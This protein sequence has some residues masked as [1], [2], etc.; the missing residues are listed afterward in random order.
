MTS[1]LCVLVVGLAWMLPAS[2][3]GREYI[4]I[5]D[6]DFRPYPMAIADFKDMTGS[7]S[8]EAKNAADVMR[9]DLGAVGV[10]KL[11]DP[12]SF[13]ADPK[14][15]GLSGASINFADWI[16]VGAEGLVKVGVHKAGDEISMDCHLFDVATG[17]ELIHKK[18]RGKPGALRSM[19]HRFAD[20]IY[21]HFTGNPSIYFTR[22]VFA[23][24][25]G[26]KTK[27]VCVMDWDGH[28]EF[29]PATGGRRPGAGR[30]R[31]RPSWPP[32]RPPARLRPSPPWGR[33]APR[34]RCG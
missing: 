12:R 18:Y 31:A 21:Q 27:E 5:S 29:C 2:S 25:T 34:G 23:K 4:T 20:A 19:V 16:N 9:F 6:P 8:D 28:S 3:P 7:A 14:H 30:R 32:S 24:R 13:I 33:A 22:I 17:K 26:H 15:E 10:F 11:L 1:R